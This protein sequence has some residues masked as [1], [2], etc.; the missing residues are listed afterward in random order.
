M[1]TIITAAMVIVDME[2]KKCMCSAKKWE[3]LDR[4]LIKR[5][6]AF[7][8]I[9]L[10]RLEICGYGN[11]KYN[12]GVVGRLIQSF[13]IATIIT[14]VAILVL[15]NLIKDC[16]YGNVIKDNF[17]AFLTIF[18]VVFAFVSSFEINSYYKKWSYLAQMFND[19][20]KIEPRDFGKHADGLRYY[21]QREHLVSCLAM[22]IFCMG[23]WNHRS[24][25]PFFK[26][27]LEK[28]ILVS[29][30]FDENLLEEKK[31]DLL[32]NFEESEVK[33]YLSG[34]NDWNRPEQDF[35]AYLKSKNV[36]LT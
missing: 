25:F 15:Y 35:I 10:I 7:L 33:K 6:F 12:T 30:S 2:T 22:D 14:I 32:S 24:F 36:G 9:L 34:Y 26:E 28:A 17:F 23:M 27:T 20:I 19:A 31:Y 3:S 1:I 13:I 16:Y 18:G 5:K 8:D 21:S 4:F 29:V 11:D